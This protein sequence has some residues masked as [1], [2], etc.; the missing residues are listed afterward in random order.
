MGRRRSRSTGSD[1]ASSGSSGTPK[2]RGFD[3]ETTHISAP[4]KIE[5]PFGV[6]T[7]AF[8]ISYGWGC[9]M[10]AGATGLSATQKRKRLFR[11]GLDR[12]SQ[13]FG[14]REDFSTESRAPLD[15]INWPKYDSIF[16]V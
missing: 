11:L 13:I 14:N 3:L 9:E 5:K 6:L 7:L 1:G 16:V 12:I 10:K 2:K 15:W 8:I 4:E